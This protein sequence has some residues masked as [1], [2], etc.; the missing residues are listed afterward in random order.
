MLSERV[1]FTRLQELARKS[2][3]HTFRL[4]VA[5]FARLSA[6]LYRT[7]G[8]RTDGGGTE[9]KGRDAGYEEAELEADIRF[10]TNPDGFP[11]VE[12]SIAGSLDL[13]CQRCLDPVTW[14]VKIGAHL[15]ILETDEQTALIDSPFDSV[16]TG[17]AGLDLKRVI[18]DEIL[19]ALPMAPVHLDGPVC[20]QAG[21]GLIDWDNDSV[22][23]A[24]SVHRPFADL[25][26]LVNGGES[27][28]EGEC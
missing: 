23:E 10:N 6:C 24:E 25:A 19:A 15:T 27:D 22:K 5:E 7:D 21:P 13:Q 16:V 18:E 12:F 11:Q 17:V 3:G 20:R 28:V 14:P 26:R 1:D 2:Q 8:R 9:A 4:S